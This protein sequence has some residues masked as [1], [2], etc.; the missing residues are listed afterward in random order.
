MMKRR[1]FITLLG[2]SAA[3]WPHAARAQQGERMRRIGWLSPSAENDPALPPNR[4][5]FLVELRKRGW[6]DGRNIRI[7]NRF[8]GGDGSRIRIL[9]AELVATAPE[10]IVV[11]GTPGAI[12]LQQSTRTIPIV[13]M[14]LPDPIANGLV[15]SI[16]R[17]GGNITGFAQYE[18]SIAAKLL[19]LLK[20]IAPRVTRVA[21]VYDPAN[22]NWSGYLAELEAAAPSLGVQMSGVALRDAV[23]IEPAIDAF[24]REPNGGLVVKASPILNRER[25]RLNARATHHGLPAVYEYRS[26]VAAGGLA[27]YGADPLE[28]YRGAA[29]YVDRILKG[30]RAGDLPVQFST[31]L[32][33]AI[34]TTTAKALGLEVPLALL[35]RADELIE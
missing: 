5:A 16:A 19:E 15:T 31:R 17:P 32:E 20:Q 4:A 12:A 21:L 10:V 18:Q 3:A 22:S 33:L 23:E 2:A 30:E 9:A 24:A 6:V 34:N 29:G 1:D 7:D 8:G 35:I 28:L 26:D 14:N 25:A 27:S 13:F 11:S